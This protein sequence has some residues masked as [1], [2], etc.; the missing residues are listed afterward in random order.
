M[1][2]KFDELV[3]KLKEIFQ[4]DKPELDFGIYKIVN[5]KADMI[6]KFLA[7]DLK[8]KVQA[9]LS[10]K[11]SAGKKAL[12]DKIAKIEATLA[13]LGVQPSSSAEW[14][15]A[16]AELDKLAAADDSESLVYAH[17]LTFFS[18]YYDDGDFI[19][20]RRYKEGQ[21]AI[22]YSGEEVKLHWANADQYYTK[23]GENFTNYDF[24]VDGK[25]VHFKL[26]Q[27]AVAKDNVKDNDCVRCFVLWDPD[28]APK[29][30][31]DGY[32]ENLSTKIL[33]VKDGELYI[34]FQYK[35]FPKGTTQKDFADAAYATILQKM[36]DEH[37]LADFPVFREVPTE[38][39]KHRTVLARE[40]TR[41]MAKNTSDY[42]IHKNLRK[43]LTQELDNY[44]KTE[45]M[46]LDDI[47]N[48]ATFDMI[49]SNLRLIQTFRLIAT[50][51]ITF[52][53]QLEDFQ[54]KLWLKKKFV[55]QCDYCITMDQVPEE[56]RAEVLANKAQL[57]EWKRLGFGDFNASASAKATADKKGAKGEQGEFDLVGAR[58]PRDR[59][60]IDARMVDTKFFDEAF[61]AKLLRSIPD[62]D[63]RC[64]GL[65]IHSENF[66]ALN[67]LQGRYRQQVK[68]IYI[69]PPYNAQSSEILYKNTFKHSSWL[70]MMANR[71]SVSLPMFKGDTVH[72]R[73]CKM[74]FC[75]ERRAA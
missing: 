71:I 60:A 15:A 11:A 14:V 68:C 18:R 21:Y 48:A 74:P 67:L 31:E 61:K 53:S 64:D 50:E 58:V 3:A 56:L 4:I 72:S 24:T 25:K 32:D 66:G 49:A 63:E 20:K 55:V 9:A 22:P 1:T 70:S 12:E 43:F 36:T 6:Q 51:L 45:M 29:E 54:K 41:Y 30:G 7:N 33:E 2:T 73:S 27:A 5:A 52:M 62:L 8:A 10:D 46:N 42:F 16:K 59:A 69:D 47:S 37:L 23:S 38:A 35:K 65:L 19:S 34:Y 40:F 75:R 44:V 26:V 57:E 28:S 39:D 13:P 17:L